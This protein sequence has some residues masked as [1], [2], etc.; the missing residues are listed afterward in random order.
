VQR[1]SHNYPEVKVLVLLVDERPEE[2]TDF[3]RNTK[4]EIIAS[5]LDEGTGNHVK[6]TEL[7]LEKMKRQVEA[8][9]HMVVS[10]STRSRA[11]AAPTTTKRAVRAASCRAVSTRRCC[12]APKALLRRGA[13]H[14]GRRQL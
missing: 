3:K 6:V 10:S 5:C 2:V 14:R 12:S 13:Q 8:G 7:V 1:D 4:A 9:D 11:S